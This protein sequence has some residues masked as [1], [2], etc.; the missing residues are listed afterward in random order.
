M[1]KVFLLAAIAG[2]ALASCAKNEPIETPKDAIAFAEPVVGLS[3][4]ATEVQATFPTNRDFKVY[5]HYYTGNYSYAA[6]SLYMPGVV[7]TYNEGGKTWKTATTY[8]WPNEGKLTFAAYSPSTVNATYDDGGFVFEDFKV[9]SDPTKQFDLLFSE[10]AYDMTKADMQTLNPYNG[11]Q[12]TFKHALSSIIIKTKAASEYEGNFTLTLN[13]LVL[14]GVCNKGTFDQSLDGTKK[15]VTVDKNAANGKLWS[16]Q[17]QEGNVAYTVYENTDGTPL[18]TTLQAIPVLTAEQ[19][20]HLILLP[21]TLTD[22]AELYIEYTLTNKLAG[23]TPLEIK[24][25]ATV[26]IKTTTVAEWLRGVRYI[27]NLTIGLDEITFNPTMVNWDEFDPA[28]N[29]Q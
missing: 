9:D 4:K 26:P 15:D 1:K 20:S 8:Y 23:A 14:R 27:Y 19:N 25:T 13:K 24:Q 22:D 17:A 10:R 5:A 28:Q 12:L 16:N 18:T 21:Q 6:G 11:V 2:V 29:I 7:A 3:T